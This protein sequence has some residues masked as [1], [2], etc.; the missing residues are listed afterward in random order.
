MP[1]ATGV[2]VAGY[3]ND[4]G[5]FEP[6]LVEAPDGV[7]DNIHF[8]GPLVFLNGAARSGISP[9]EI[10]KSDTVHGGY[11]YAWTRDIARGLEYEGELKR[12]YGIVRI[13]ATIF[14]SFFDWPSGSF[15]QSF[16]AMRREEEGMVEKRGLVTMLI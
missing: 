10:V 16:V 5:V 7:E 6:T 8:F 3:D 2:F 11:C 14:A 13:S 4:T 1:H 9:I 15:K 12:H